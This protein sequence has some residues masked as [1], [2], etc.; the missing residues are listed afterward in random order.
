MTRSQKK[1][2]ASQM[3]R[4]GWNCASI[5]SKNSCCYPDIADFETRFSR[6]LGVYLCDL[7]RMSKGVSTGKA[8]TLWDSSTF[9][10]YPLT[11]QKV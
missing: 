11:E 3:E 10:E 2:T 6:E 8:T 1:T 4:G 7:G 5:F 9:A